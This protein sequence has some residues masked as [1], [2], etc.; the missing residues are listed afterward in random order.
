MR[1]VISDAPYGLKAAA[2]NVQ[3]GRQPVGSSTAPI[4]ADAAGAVMRRVNQCDVPKLCIPLELP[5]NFAESTIVTLGMLRIASALNALPQ[6]IIATDSLI[7]CFQ[8]FM[9]IILLSSFV[10]LTESDHQ[11]WASVRQR[12]DDGAAGAH[13]PQLDIDIGGH[14]RQCTDASNHWSKQPMESTFSDNGQTIRGTKAR[15]T[16]AAD[17]VQKLRETGGQEVNNLMTDVQDLLGRVAHVADPEIARLRTKVEQ[18]M[19]AAKKVLLDGTD[20]VQR[21][22]KNAISAGDGYVRDQPWQAVGIAAVAG[23]VVGFLAARR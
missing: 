19:T 8:R 6:S 2:T 15:E 16:N 17:A 11:V 21:H 13:C 23:L 14:R 4:P 18:G 10:E 20:Q 9:A 22:A 3:R 7:D 5:P 12:T 1:L